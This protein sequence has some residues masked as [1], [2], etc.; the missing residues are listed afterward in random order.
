[1]LGQRLERIDLACFKGE[2]IELV[3]CT[4]RRWP[5]SELRRVARLVKDREID[6]IHTHMSSAHFFGALLR[7]GFGIPRVATAH[8]SRFQPHWLFNDFVIAVSQETYRFQHR[9]NLVPR[10]KLAV[11]Y[12]AIDTKRF[13]RADEQLISR[14]RAGWRLQQE[15]FAIGIVGDIIARKDQLSLVRAMPDILKRH[16]AAKLIMV[17][18][19]ENRNG[20][21]VDEA[22]IRRVKHAADALRVTDNIVWH[23]YSRDIP[24]IMRAMDV[25]AVPS[26]S[27]T[28]GLVAAEAMA[29][30][31]PVVAS[32]VGGLV[33]IVASEENGLL[34][35]PKRPKLLA[36]QILR[37]LDDAALRRAFGERGR[38]SVE[39]RFSVDQQLASVQAVY[40]SVLLKRR[41][42][43]SKTSSADANSNRAA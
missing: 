15:E 40:E 35:P 43:V 16:P 7:I 26:L 41:R 27:E 20:L 34:A 24:A 39:T 25:C 23:G 12:S 28:F 30:H 13:D 10:S 21:K 36:K 38:Q 42:R 17:G 22:Y 32:N 29:A 33:E 31:T 1:M 37:L 6:L 5:T 18:A 19:C 8:C 11:V 9:Y 14:I 2:P 4:F 3:D